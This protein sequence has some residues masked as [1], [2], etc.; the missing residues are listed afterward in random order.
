MSDAS[1]AGPRNAV[2]LLLDSLTGT[3]SAAT[4]A[5]SSIPPR[6]IAWQRARCASS[7]PKVVMIETHVRFAPPRK[8]V[9]DFHPMNYRDRTW[10]HG[11]SLQSYYEMA[12][13][14]GYS[15]CIA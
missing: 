10:N 9:I 12:K 5:R 1:P 13:K 11:A 3:C 8:M 7:W 14:K 15:W 6:S 2:V 4:A